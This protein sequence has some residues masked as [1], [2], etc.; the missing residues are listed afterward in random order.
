MKTRFSGRNWVLDKSFSLENQFVGFT[1]CVAKSLSSTQIPV[2][3][4]TAILVPGTAGMSSP[5]KS[6]AAPVFLLGKS[7][8]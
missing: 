5:H 7:D 8:I 2:L 6:K 1:F 4:T 3:S